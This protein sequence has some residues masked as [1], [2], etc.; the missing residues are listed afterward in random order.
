MGGFGPK[1]DDC[2]KTYEEPTVKAVVHLATVGGPVRGGGRNA[3]QL[4]Q[5]AGLVE[6]SV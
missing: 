2:Q 1:I 5:L 4:R 3:G 6:P